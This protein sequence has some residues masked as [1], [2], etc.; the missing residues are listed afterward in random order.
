MLLVATA[1]Y[2]WTDATGNDRSVADVEQ[3]IRKTLGLR[4]DASIDPDAVPEALMVELGDA[5]MA[6]HVGNERQHEWM[7]EMMGGEG[8]A[9]L[10]SAHR[11]I[12]YNYLAGGYSGG[13][14]FGM[15]HGF[16]MS[17][18]MMGGR[19]WGLMGNPDVYRGGFPVETPREILDRR[20]ASGEIMRQEYLQM[21]EDIE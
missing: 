5:V 2:G 9:S 12:A 17:G 7:D 3:E 11:W 10:D 1:I 19:G 6:E 4:Q 8:S 20:Y 15:M 21:L 13:R 16:V 18:S 14:G